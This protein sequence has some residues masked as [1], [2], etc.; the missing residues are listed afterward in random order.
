MA[1]SYP[2]FKGGTDA[3]KLPRSKPTG[4]VS[5]TQFS[6]SA[7]E[8]AS[9]LTNFLSKPGPSRGSKV[10]KRSAQIPTE[11]RGER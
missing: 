11:E 9:D 6:S 2:K 4:I 10:P 8:N 5:S 1:K 3:Q 7:L